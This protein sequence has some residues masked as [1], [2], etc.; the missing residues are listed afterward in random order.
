MMMQIQASSSS[1]SAQHPGHKI[2]LLEE[3]PH[4]LDDSAL[5]LISAHPTHSL[6]RLTFFVTLGNVP[7][8][9][10]ALEFHSAPSGFSNRFSYCCTLV[11]GYG[12]SL[13]WNWLAFLSFFSLMMT[14]ENFASLRSVSSRPGVVFR[15]L[16]LVLRFLVPLPAQEPWPSARR[17]RRVDLHAP[18]RAGTCPPSWGHRPR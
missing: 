3:P 16:G 10:P 17:P 13:T 11:Y 4:R 1:P 15:N 9:W 5:L 6:R 7:R 18:S 8:W 14:F 12:R 2:R